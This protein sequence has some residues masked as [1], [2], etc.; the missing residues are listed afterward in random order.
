MFVLFRATKLVMICNINNKLTT[1]GRE[2]WKQ[3][4]CEQKRELRVTSNLSTSRR[5]DD[6]QWRR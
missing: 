4:R 6:S 2:S 1:G 5:G 3:V